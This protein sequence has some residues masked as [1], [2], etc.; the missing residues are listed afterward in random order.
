LIVALTVLATIYGQAMTFTAPALA[1]S[2]A[3]VPAARPLD[4][5]STISLHAVDAQTGDPIPNF[6]WMVNLDNSHDNTAILEHIASYSPPVAV[7]AVTD[8]SGVAGGIV[9]P[10]TEAPNRGYLVTVLA[11]DGAGALNDPDYRIGG[12]PFRLPEDAGAIVVE[13]EPHPLPLATVRVKVFHDNK[14]VNNAEDIP[15]EEGLA[16]FHITLHDRIGEVVT[17]WYGN[18][19]CTD[20]YP[21][22]VPPYNL[23]VDPAGSDY[24]VDSEGN[25]VPIPGTGGFCVSDANGDVVVKNM[26]PDKYAV[27]AIPPDG[28]AWIQTSTIEGHFE[29]D[30]WVAEGSTGYATEGELFGQTVVWFGFIRPCT[31]GNLTDDCTSTHANL[32]G[33][34][35]RITGRVRAVALD[36]E[37]PI[38]ELGRVVPRPYLA[39]NNIGGDDEQVWMGRGNADGTFTIPNVPVGLYQLVVWD[40]PL[41]QIISFLTVEVTQDNCIAG[42]LGPCTV[43]M[44]DIGVP[45]WFG[46]TLGTAYIDANEN[47]VRD[48]GERGLPRQDL[49]TRFK[50]GTIQYA[51]V[52]DNKGNYRFDEVFPNLAWTITEVGYGRFKNT[53]AAAYAT[54]LEGNPL[55]YPWV[56]DCTDIDS[57]PVSPCTPGSAVRECTN[58][59]DWRTCEHGPI[60]QDLGLAGLLQATINWAG[61]TNYIDWGKKAFAPGENGGI[62]GIVFNAVT[63]NE[64]NARL[65]AA[66]D[67]EP[68]IPGAVIKLYA[69]KRDG[70]G[71]I[72]YD[73]DTG[74]VMKDHLA[75]IYDGADSWYDSLPTD[76]NPVSTMGRDPTE[77]QPYPAIWERCL[78]LL[79]LQNQTRPGVFDGGYAF[80]MDCTNPSATD[81]FD[82]AQLGDPE[83][84]QCTPVAAGDWVV[85][86]EP[87]L[88]YQV[89]KE[90]NINV[91]SGDAFI[92]QIPPPPCAGPL[93]TV[94]VV[95]NLA[96]ANFA[97]NDPAHTQG[98]YN[99]DFLATTSPL[100]P[101]GG[102]PYE[103]RRMPLCNARLVHLQ[104]G[105]NANSDFFFFTEVPPPGR[106]QGLLTDDLNNEL[107]P[108]MP[109]Y[110]DKRGIPN[111]P[112]GI[113]D[114]KGKLIQVVYTDDNGYFEALVP[115]TGTYNCPL[116][117]G[118]C[119]GMYEVIGNDPGDPDNPT[120]WNPNYG[121][122]KLELD[123]WPGLTT[124]ADVAIL[125]ITS[126]VATPGSQFETAFEC[127]VP[128][129]TPNVLSVSQP[130][131][132]S[133]N[134]GS[135][136]INGAGFGDTQGLGSVKLDSVS[137]SATSWTSTTIEVSMGQLSLVS[138][139]PHQLLVTNNSGA[140]SPL[141][142]TFHVLGAGYNPPQV[143]VDI[144][145]GDDTTG[146]GSAGSPYKTVQKALDVAA[147]GSLVLV[148]P[149]TYYESVIID[150]NLKL[151]GYGP[152]ASSID[153]RFFGLTSYSPADF[154]AKVLS[155]AYDGPVAVPHGQSITVLAENGEFGAGGFLPQIDGFA[156]R[157]ATRWN[158]EGGGIYVHAY[159]RNLQI[160]N[161]LIQ[162]NAGLH[163]GGIK[164]GRPYTDNP[165]AGN[166]R[167]AENDNIRIHH[168]RVLNNGG[169]LSAGG[170]GIFNG[171]ENYEIDHN[172]VCG[173]YSAEYGAGISNFGFSSGSIH[174]NQ[175]KFNNAFDEGGGIMVAG[176]E[177]TPPLAISAGSGNVDILRNLIQHNVSN[178]D[179]GGIRL[180][181][182][183]DGRV[184]IIN[185]MIANNL[186]TD[187]GGGISLD[188]ALN[189]QIV[190]NTVARNIS[191]ATAEDADRTTCVPALHPSNPLATCPHGAG[192]VSQPHSPALITARGLPAGSFSNPLLFDNIF[193]RNE[194]FY[195]D[196]TTGL[197]GGGLPSVGYIDFEV[198]QSAGSFSG[199][200]NNCSAFS[201]S[202]L[203][204]GTNVTTDPS[205]IQSV[206]IVF[207]A[208]AFAGDP[209]FITVLIQSTPDDPPGNYHLN[210]S[211]AAIDKGTGSYLGR[212]APVDD[213]DGDGRPNGA[214]H[215][216][217]ADEQPGAAPGTCT[218]PALLFFSTALDTAVP[219]VSGTPDDADI[220]SWDGL[221]FARAFD[222]TA[223]GLPDGA[224]LDAV[225]VV[226]SD[227]FYMSFSNN[228]GVTVP[229]GVGTVQDEDIVRYD[230]GVWSLY[231]DGSDVGL[232]DSNAED[233]DAFEILPD[234]RVV[235]STSGNPTIPSV[236]TPAPQDEDL[237][238]CDGTF[239]PTTTCTWSYYFDGSDVT[240]TAGGENVDG[241]AVSGSNLY[242]TTQGG[243]SVTGLSG[244]GEDVFICNS[245]TTGAASGCMSFSMYFDGSAND[246]TD[247]LDAID[248]P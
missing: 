224:S 67:Y 12:E 217:G 125:P 115:S 74:A 158:G 194:A 2:S 24:G 14:P 133:A 40:K 39:L 204:D 26:G 138:T 103:G 172:V 30:A 152:D 210:S 57:N 140:T 186:A 13:L 21:P 116:P 247:N 218:P 220:Y 147:D 64:L 62:V 28:T 165:D 198:L 84:G 11:N 52:A 163:G 61:L 211:S 236:T 202:C 85:E 192:L 128:A 149:G 51:T 205:F 174:D 154:D 56:N 213:F 206:D 65:Q 18:P 132:S 159:G 113:R 242:L 25:Y 53:G 187:T 19:I 107:D 226:D 27:E 189:V 69:P 240:L 29:Q 146:N 43:A 237:F 221:N 78:E 81:P 60:N 214:T 135:F 35:G 203:N 5:T 3:S 169:L 195:L 191:T 181:T 207:Q 153:G 15:V 111:A 17:D 42:N 104:T 200:Y 124:L 136:F 1:T 34:Q 137:L 190:N 123:I 155:L 71:R 4:Q 178:D 102:S 161:N 222:A 9:L 212:C 231:F 243:F 44:G 148:H 108:N 105:Q 168:N 109:M 80:D 98:V 112:I 91:F 94:D 49:D 31:F 55:N 10:D 209:A 188:D 119:P 245:A 106:L 196:G 86:V 166:T 99:P 46:R 93:H 100:A 171:A 156:I 241:V 197:Y 72:M 164:L 235:V 7:G 96:N 233:V 232:S 83:L 215:D 121:S 6:K 73:P 193:W 76:C 92:P 184:R 177:P 227:T 23:A 82:P 95:D 201:A 185:N 8:G 41:D 225:V 36:A 229:G 32:S 117:A 183:I 33:R 20:Y 142:I 79:S 139:G 199:H 179:G 173:N 66:E 75:A 70:S 88:G 230:A 162:S 37:V 59:D 216:L 110:G 127:N 234:G 157:G 176:E 170:I 223:L 58:V 151:Q 130:Y 246:I 77:V 182:P 248:L 145:T 89:V 141:G 219:G 228:G 134:P 129:T 48:P 45:D 22:G 47:G 144:A 150:E 68:G 244:G 175:I 38:T 160:S 63:R 90:E 87:P 54:D 238:R 50:D 97:L 120:N 131:G 126:F 239:G 143:H 122:L 208:L 180:L 118:P 101:L 167:N 114:F 16:G